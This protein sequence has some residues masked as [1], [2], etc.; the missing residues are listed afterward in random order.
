MPSE[1]TL[2]LHHPGPRPAFYRVA[3]HLWGAGC[4]V[5]SDGDSRTADDEQWTELTLILRDSSQQRL[6]IDPL[7]LAPLVLLIRASQA[8]L[9]ERAAHFIQSV[10]GGTLQ[11]HIKDR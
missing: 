1:P 9:G 4:N 8:G 11:A 3:E 2:L 10:A 6:D 5:D 7:S